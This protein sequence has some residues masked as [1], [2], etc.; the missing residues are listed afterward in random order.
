MQ[1]VDAQLILSASDL[2]NFL[3]CPH[4]TTLDLARARGELQVEPEL[5]ADAELLAAKGDQHE[6]RY[7]ESLE[8]VG[9]E[10]AMI[11][12]AGG[13]RA[14]L[15]P[16]LAATGEAMRAGAEVIYQAPFLRKGLRGHADFLSRVERPPALGPYSYEVADPK[17]ARRAK[18][19]FILQLSFYS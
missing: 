8:A 17:L 15:G 11:A 10:V 4:L 13:S 5:G 1:I 14:S 16:A 6:R 7:L 18:P 19:Y 2:N 12:A 9:R 3:A